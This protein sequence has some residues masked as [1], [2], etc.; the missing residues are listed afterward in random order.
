[1]ESNECIDII[2]TKFKTTGNCKMMNG[3]C[4]YVKQLALEKDVFKRFSVIQ[5]FSVTGNRSWCMLH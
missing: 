4:I 2:Q 1:M 3:E 5:E